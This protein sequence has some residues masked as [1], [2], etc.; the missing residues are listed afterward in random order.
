MS[1]TKH[2]PGPW[3]VDYSGPA[4]I[5][6]VDTSGSEVALCSKQNDDGD[7][8]EA[9]ARLIAASPELFEACKVLLATGSFNK[10]GEHAEQA[11]RFARAAIDKATKGAQ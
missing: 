3:A 5:A 2:T 4:R 8:D 9:N 6:I 10:H 7:T 1:T 11:A